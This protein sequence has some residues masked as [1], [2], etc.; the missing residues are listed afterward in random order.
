M[1]PTIS[2]LT[3]GTLS[4][5]S[6]VTPSVSPAASSQVV[7]VLASTNLSSAPTVSGLGLTWA[8]DVQYDPFGGYR[9]TVVLIG[10]GT[11]TPGAITIT[12]GGADTLGG[13]YAVCEVASTSGKVQSATA[14]EAAASTPFVVPY[15]GAWASDS[16]GLA[17]LWNLGG[18]AHSVPRAGW[19][20]LLDDT[21]FAIHWRGTTDT[22]ASA[23]YTASG[24]EGLAAQGYVLEF[25]SGGP[26]AI[27][28]TAG[29]TAVVDQKTVTLS[30]TSTPG[31]AALSSF[32]VDWGDGTTNGLLAHTYATGGTYSPVLTETD[33]G[34]LTDDYSEA[35]TTQTRHTVRV[36]TVGG[37]SASDTVDVDDA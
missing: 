37:G 22:A 14:S 34:A 35:V 19:T 5:T 6:V 36:Q 17:V 24:G 23:D 27:G 30:R 32:T 25:G 8:L 12:A 7:V 4:G 2:L 29:Y 10:T 9:D 11:A 16:T 33:A 15:A 31:D 21:G 18:N 1:A 20:E 3:N 13:Q 28:P 26:A